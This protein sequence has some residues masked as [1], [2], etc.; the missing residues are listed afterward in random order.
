MPRFDAVAVERVLGTCPKALRRRHKERVALV[1]KKK[2]RIFIFFIVFCFR[3]GVAFTML[4]LLTRDAT[5][6]LNY[7]LGKSAVF[8]GHNHNFQ[9][10][11]P[12][13]LVFFLA[14]FF[15]E[16]SAFEASFLAPSKACIL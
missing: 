3:G 14:F 10:I 13:N 5:T 16:S 8:L 2:W 9:V 6:K 15:L 7:F 11:N 12:T 1:L 4:V